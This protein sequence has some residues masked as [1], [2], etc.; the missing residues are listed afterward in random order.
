MN[1]KIIVVTPP[2]ALK[3][4][5][6]RQE[7]IVRALVASGALDVRGGSFTAHFDGDGELRKVDRNDTIYRT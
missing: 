3:A 5:L 4:A 7:R 1:P 6:E 2:D